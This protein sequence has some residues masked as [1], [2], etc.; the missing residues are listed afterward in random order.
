MVL[1]VFSVV[2]SLMMKRGMKLALSGFILV[3]VVFTKSRGDCTKNSD[4]LSK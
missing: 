2:A 1:I 3:G 4:D